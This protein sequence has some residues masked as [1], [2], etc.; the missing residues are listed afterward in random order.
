MKRGLVP[1]SVLL[2]A[3]A[4]CGGLANDPEAQA[5]HSDGRTDVSW[6]Q[7]LAAATPTPEGGFIAEWDLSFPSEVALRA[8]YDANVLGITPKL[9]V[10]RQATDPS[11]EATY[12]R[13]D[14][15]DIVYC[16]SDAF[17][18]SFGNK[19]TVVADMELA[20]GEWEAVADVVFRYDSSRDATCDA[21]NQ[22]V[23][24]AVRPYAG[25]N[26]LACA[27]PKSASWP[28][29]PGCGVSGVSGII[30]VLYINYV[31]I[32]PP[33]PPPPG[34]GRCSGGVD[35]A[36]AGLSPR[37][38]LRHELGHM[39]GFR[40]EHP[41]GPNGCGEEQTYLPETSRD[42]SGRQLTAW[43]QNS[44]MQYKACGGVH[45]TD[46][47]ISPLDGVGTRLVYGIPRPWYPGVLS[48]IL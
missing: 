6:E 41:W 3:L 30:G 5:T 35:V 18:T 19:P 9:V 32:P 47:N 8:H 1:W 21:N 14:A 42:F 34:V 37:G 46:F 4:G 43:D 40:H 36:N 28:G 11:R 24:I 27:A 48:G 44:V 12:T 25:C 16:V 38:V 20:T 23:D 33:G 39:L 10:L 31:R 22:N 17:T 15:R 26:F 45:G 2:V 13:A 7:Y 29:H